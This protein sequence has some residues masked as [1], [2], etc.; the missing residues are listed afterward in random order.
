MRRA[1]IFFFVI[2]F[3][4]TPVYSAQVLN[5][6]VKQIFSESDSRGGFYLKEGLKDCMWDLL[7]IDLSKEAGRAQFSLLKEAKI[8]NWTLVRIDYEKNS[9]GTCNLTGLHVS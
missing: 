9:N 3:I 1:I 2:I 8:H 4:S 5:L 6:H 7:Y